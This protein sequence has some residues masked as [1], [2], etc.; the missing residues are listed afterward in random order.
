M[1]NNIRNKREFIAKIIR[2]S[3]M[4][5][6]LERITAQKQPGLVVLTYH[7]IADTRTDLFYD[8]VIS[9]SPESLYDQ[10]KWLSN[11]VRLLTLNEV[12]AQVESGTP[13]KEPVAILTFDDG[14][15]DNFYRAVPILRECNAP[16]TFFI[17]TAFIDAPCVPWWDH[18][19]YVI[20]RT[21]V[22]WFTLEQNQNSSQTPLTIDLR[23][24]S[25]TAAIT[26]IIR[27]FLDN[28]IADECRFLTQLGERAEVDVD[29]KQLGRE[30]F[31]TWDQIQ[32]LAD[33]KTG[34][35]IGSH[36]HSHRNLAS[37]D[38]DAQ[39]RELTD[40]KQILE[41][42]LGRPVKALAYPFGWP[43]TYTASTKVLAAQA[44]YTI[45]FSSQEGVNQFVGFDRYD[46]RRMGVGSADSIVLI[47]ARSALY[48]AFGKSFV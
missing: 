25:R 8:P 40:S 45:A 42:R 30:L 12:I 23:T 43:G 19:A 5:A 48:S 9:A 31:M 11:R 26:T 15:A 14:Y 1:L 6:L 38:H 29:C 36:A 34:L 32:R 33:S 17:P 37:L 16:A 2:E 3:G 18:V 35:S 21:Q 47:Q 24:V 46:V 39:R 13:W 4:L 41:N 7:R 22:L 20:K 44:G 10:V 27:A 28:K